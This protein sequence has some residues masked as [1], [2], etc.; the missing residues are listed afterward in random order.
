MLRENMGWDH[1]KK[2]KRK[3][4]TRERGVGGDWS[5]GGGKP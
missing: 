4:I 5:G 2:K 3:K 1:K